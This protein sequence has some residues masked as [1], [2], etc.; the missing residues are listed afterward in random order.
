MNPYWGKSFFA[1]ISTF[2][3]RLLHFLSPTTESVALSSDEIQIFTLVFLSISSAIVG[4][5]LVTKK[6][7][8]LANSLSHTVLL[9]IVVSTLFS[10]QTGSILLGINLKM[11]VGAAL[12]TGLITVVSTEFLVKVIRLQKDA[13]IGLVF[14]T[15][16]ALG[17]VLVTAL[18]R[19]SHIGI[20]AIMGNVDGIH[21]DDLK[22]AV[23]LALL[24]SSI[25]ILFFNRLKCYSFD[26]ILA[27]NFGLGTF[28][29]NVIL[30]SQTSLTAIG[31]FRAV[32]VFLFLTLIV[33]PPITARLF[34]D[35]LSI[36]ILLSALF[37]SLASLI[38]VAVSRHVLSIHGFPL[39]TSGILTVT[40]GLMFGLSL[41]LCKMMRIIRSSS[42]IKLLYEKYFNFRKHGIN[43][44]EHSPSS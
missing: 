4:C 30:M 8:M 5:F 36:L 15:L 43:R 16:F 42:R 28:F 7:T 39:S 20:E 13:S 44:N 6:M 22:I 1:F 14:T 23:Y 37:G 29:L 12:I 17:I 40:L 33:V 19:N 27:K 32:G 34:T 31:S 21:F 18:F 38:A 41:T 3:Y 10:F 24:N 2:F 35:R 9:G 25:A 11:L 26:P